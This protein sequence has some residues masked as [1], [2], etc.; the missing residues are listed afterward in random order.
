MKDERKVS[1]G[2]GGG[3]GCI[4]CIFIFMQ[5]AALIDD[6]GWDIFGRQAFGFKISAS[7]EKSVVVEIVK[8]TGPTGFLII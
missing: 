6:L 8:N 4:L 7:A 3:H 5:F 1:G 2:V